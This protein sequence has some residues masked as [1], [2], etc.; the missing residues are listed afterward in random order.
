MK[1]MSVTLLLLV[2]GLTIGITIENRLDISQTI[3]NLGLD[4]EYDDQV[5]EDDSLKVK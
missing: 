1:K 2:I 3:S 4:M 5:M